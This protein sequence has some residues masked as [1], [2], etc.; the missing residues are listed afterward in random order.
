MTKSRSTSWS[1]TSCANMRA[2]HL[3]RVAQRSSAPHVVLPF[4]VRRLFWFAVTLWV[5]VTVSF[6]LMR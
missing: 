3:G 2:I 5:V 6:F 1:S 4:L